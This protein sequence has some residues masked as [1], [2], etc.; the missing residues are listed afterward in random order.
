MSEATN[1]TRYIE[2]NTPIGLLVVTSDGYAVTGV[3]MESHR[4]GPVNRSAWVRDEE[5]EGS[6]L[7]AARAQLDE[8][9][10]GSRLAFALP[11]HAEGTALQQAVWSAL[12]RKMFWMVISMIL[13][14]H[15]C[16]VP[17]KMQSSN[18]G[19]FF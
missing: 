10:A 15:F 14:K 6:P 17:R 11:L 4:H 16:W 2:L 7:R 8:Y 13:S 18:N 19:Q 12:T 9:F 5:T 1:R 3:Y